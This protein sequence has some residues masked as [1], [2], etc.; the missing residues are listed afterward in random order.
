MA[1]DTAR[2]PQS[3]DVETADVAVVDSGTKAV[4]TLQKTAAVQSIEL[5]TAV[6][7]THAGPTDKG[8][9]ALVEQGNVSGGGAQDAGDA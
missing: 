1:P 8:S 4:D 5:S 2:A 7:D 9:T 6:H 3:R